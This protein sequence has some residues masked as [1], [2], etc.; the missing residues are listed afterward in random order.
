MLFKGVVKFIN[1]DASN[2][3]FPYKSMHNFHFL[4]NILSEDNEG[5]WLFVSLNFV[6][7]RAV[8]HCT[9]KQKAF[10]LNLVISYNFG[11]NARTGQQSQ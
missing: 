9:R 11:N 7:F 6:A 10:G 1:A 8:D 3:V 4:K 5:R 2:F